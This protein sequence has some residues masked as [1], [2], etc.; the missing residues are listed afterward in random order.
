MT[1][2]DNIKNADVE[3]HSAFFVFRWEGQAYFLNMKLKIPI[4]DPVIAKN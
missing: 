2:R 3:M 4:T 1:D